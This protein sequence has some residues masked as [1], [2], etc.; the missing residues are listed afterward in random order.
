MTI[1]FTLTLKKH[2]IDVSSS[3]GKRYIINSTSCS[4]LGFKFHGT[5]KH[6]QAAS[7]HDLIS[8]IT[9]KVVNSK[10]TD[11]RLE[12]IRKFLGSNN[13]TISDQ[14]LYEIEVV[15]TRDTLPSKI[16]ELAV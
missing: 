11:L 10:V 13:I 9:T 14:K 15:V 1:D 3:S 5:C 7:N 12:A 16:L 6:F 4:C 8:K 2:H